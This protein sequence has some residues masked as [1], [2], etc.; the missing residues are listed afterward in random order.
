M[1]DQRKVELILGIR[2]TGE[3]DA[4]KGLESISLAASALTE[5]LSKLERTDALKELGQVAAQVAADTGNLDAAAAQLAKELQSIGAT[6]K[7]I[8]LVGK[9]FEQT[10]NEIEKAAA[11]QAKLN[12]RAEKD[13]QKV[14]VAQ[15]RLGAQMSKD[16]EDELRG[17]TKLNEQR[18]L[19]ATGATNLQKELGSI[20]R[21][22]QLQKL[23]T[24][25]GTLAKKTG[26]VSGAVKDLDKQLKS[27]GAS[28]DEV[29]SVAQAFNAAQAESDG[30]GGGKGPNLLQR[31]G[32]QGRNLPAVQIPGAGISTDAISNLTRLTGALGEA[33][34]VTKLMASATALL[35]PVL[36]ASAASVAGVL[37]V[38]GPLVII[39]GG[40]GLALKA[41]GDQA[42]AESKAINAI[43]DAQ[44][45]VAQQIAEGLGSEEAKKQLDELNAKRKAEADLLAKNQQIY[46]EN[47]E[48][49]GALTGVLKATSGAEQALS[50]QIQKSKD[51]IEGYDTSTQALTQALD[52]G[53]LA[54]ND[55]AEAEKKLAEER[56][57]AVLSAAD[58][59]GKELAAQQKALNATEE[60]NTKRLEAIDDEKAVIQ[61]QIDVLTESGDT[62]EEVAKKIAALNGQLG[63]LGKESEFI[64]KTALEVSRA[65]DAEKKAKKDAEDAAKK[66]EQAQTQYTKSIENA[67]RQFLQ[68][69]QDI[70]TRYRN[71]ASDN[72]LKFNR[73]II[74]LTT[75]FHRDEFDIQLKANRAERDAA[76]DQQNDLLKIREDANKEEAAA[77]Q[78]GDFKALFLARQKAQE[79]LK[80]EE[81]T[82]DTARQ[83]RILDFQDARADAL[84]AAERQRLDRMQGYTRQLAD[85]RTAQDRDLAQARLTR[86]RATQMASE[87]LNAEL[88]IR[89]QFWN[90]TVKQAQNALNQINGMQAASGQGGTSGAGQFS[91]SFAARTI[92]RVI[93]K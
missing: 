37:A 58:V 64:T 88:G 66:A 74:D 30:G 39:I 23:G 7:E 92:A 5:N 93:R 53:T 57:K 14:R 6:E 68:S 55:A 85:A 43:V 87:A 31:L 59:A 10:T 67:G 40:L 50:D 44:R 35:T 21:S 8:R 61:A 52:D 51:L 22:D 25:M 73:D 11:A 56:T 1:A 9:A 60:Q 70:S 63:S 34:G 81:A 38:A 89:Q 48:N 2:T 72:E 82:Q 18:R 20:S 71:L 90:A 13:A 3:T 69:T 26:D 91:G 78:E 47:I 42:A 16:I 45:D 79:M 46:N 24:E 32:A 27:L 76:L 19:A 28:K 86:Q 17:Q 65:N 29:R 84:R 33:A 75:K 80:Q 62:S 36:G 41:L 4:T 54:A 83:K 15:E 49:Q 77:I 12:E